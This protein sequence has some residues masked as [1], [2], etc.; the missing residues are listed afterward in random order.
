MV[1]CQ[2]VSTA[3]WS[4]IRVDINRRVI[5][6]QTLVDLTVSNIRQCI[7]M[8]WLFKACDA[9]TFT[10]NLRRCQV[11]ALTG[12]GHG[13]YTLAVGT[14]RQ[15]IDMRSAEINTR[16][17]L[18]FSWYRCDLHSWPKFSLVS[19]FCRKEPPVVPN[20]ETQRDNV[21]SVVYSCAYGYFRAGN[22]HVSTCNRQTG[23]WTP[24][25]TVCTLVDCG[26]PPSV[27]GALISAGQT[28]S[29]GSRVELSCLPPYYVNSQANFM[30][31]QADGLWSPL[32][33]AEVCAPCDQSG[34]TSGIS[35][36]SLELDTASERPVADTAHFTCRAGYYA[37][38]VP[39]NLVRCASVNKTAIWQGLKNAGCAQT[40]WEN[41]KPKQTHPTVRYNYNF[42]ADAFGPNGFRACADVTFV[43]VV[44]VVVV[45]VVVVVVGIIV[46]I[47][48][49]VVVVV[50]VVIVEIL[51]A[52]I[53]VVVVVVVVYRT[54]VVVVI[55]VIIVVI[56]EEVVVVVV[57]VVA[58]VVVEVEVVEVVVV[59]VEEVVVVVVEVV[60]V[61]SCGSSRSSSSGSIL[62]A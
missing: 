17:I 61:G 26:T 15:S 7:R 34:E 37:Y 35:E 52:V 62:N 45:V 33:V 54:I 23:S 58:V 40:R 50:V 44:G 18:L 46:V 31:C 20:S 55:V 16:L 10:L 22:D 24:V 3:R 59:V 11:F 8:C 1:N 2:L 42:D 13:A 4:G 41:P 38:G 53:E 39:D 47:V 5:G 48:G 21:K 14:G 43:G 36:G 57:I 9:L 27:P 32:D 56:V 28:T 25:D 49:E 30:Q 12:S 29:Y 6:G 51:V 19:E 60:V